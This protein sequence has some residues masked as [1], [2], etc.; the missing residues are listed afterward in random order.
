MDYNIVTTNSTTT[1][2]TTSLNTVSAVNTHDEGNIKNI[3]SE[4]MALLEYYPSENNKKGSASEKTQKEKKAILQRCLKVLNKEQIDKKEIKDDLQRICLKLIS[5]F[6]PGDSRKQEY[7]TQLNKGLDKIFKNNSSD[8]I[9]TIFLEIIMMMLKLMAMSMQKN[10]KDLEARDKSQLAEFNSKIE[11]ANDLLKK[12]QI[13]NGVGLGLSLL[14]VSAQAYG[15][16]FPGEIGSQIC[17]VGGQAFE[18]SGNAI[19]NMSTASFDVKAA[20]DSAKAKYADFMSQSNQH[21]F[22]INNKTTQETISRVNQFM[23]E[24]LPLIVF[25]LHGGFFK[26][27]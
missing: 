21:M 8:S 4:V 3:T 17:N 18:K 6:K 23:S 1:N 19:A 14:S 7:S 10:S 25:F 13:L 22:D 2:S 16:A 24:S 27:Q 20:T 9:Q 12:N 11:S 5:S 26:N 15:A